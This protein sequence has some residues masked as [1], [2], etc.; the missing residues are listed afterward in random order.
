MYYPQNRI[1][2]NLYTNGDEYVIEETNEFYKGSY[3]KTFEG[4]FYTGK[5]PNDKPTQKLKKYVPS[6]V[7][8]ISFINQ[9]ST[10]QLASTDGFLE[11]SNLSVVNV[12]NVNEY[13]LL[14]NPNLTSI[15]V[16]DTI[17]KL[18]VTYYPSPSAED[19]T[20]GTFTR[21]FVVKTN[22]F[23]FT[24][25]E[26]NTYTLIKN[27]DPQWVWELFIPFAV[28]WVITGEKENVY[29]INKDTI[30]IVEQR[31]KKKG[32]QQYLKENYTKFWKP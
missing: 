30:L 13:Y 15:N 20:I 21:Y 19:Y 6:T 24:E 3:W 31:L 23:L 25:V 32:L 10:N 28:S 4:K 5:T 9:N 18:P 11:E 12:G 2:T 14:K 26:K 16:E 17:K 1:Q 7:T 8:N 29:K 27:Q 22:E